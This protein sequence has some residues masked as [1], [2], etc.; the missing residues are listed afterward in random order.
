[1]ITE[2]RPEFIGV[3][4]SEH[5]LFTRTMT[6]IPSLA[7][8]KKGRL[9]ATWYAGPTPAEDQ[10]NYCV[11][12]TSKDGGYTW[13]EVCI[14]DPDGP[15][16][17]R[18]FDPEIWIG[19]DNILRWFWCD[20][21]GTGNTG[22]DTDTLW[23]MEIGDPDFVPPG[24]FPDPRSIGKGVMMSKPII[25]CDGTWAL[26]VSKRFKDYSV[27]MLVS[28][29]GGKT[30]STRGAATIPES[31]RTFDEHHFVQLKNG[32]IWCLARTLS[33]IRESISTDCGATWSELIPSRIRH[34]SSR[35]FISRLE[36]GNLLLVKHGSI[37]VQ[38]PGREKLMAFISKDDGESWKGGLMLDER[39]GVSYPDGQ[40]AADGTLFITYDYDRY[41][42]R[43]ILFAVFTEADVL[44]GKNASGRVRLRNIISTHG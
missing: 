5:A 22:I 15:G 36:S 38:T 32:N 25:L 30:F 14:V 7:I 39:E 19:P 4:N 34:T 1:M 16:P 17:R 3:P 6:G 20:R 26:P 21:S 29:D 8:S 35:F 23:M 27:E 11:L 13:K 12:T 41:G 18:T 2:K 43:Q 44:T 40:Q 33:G 31:D 9:W 42:A 10:N 24:K 37:A 28:V